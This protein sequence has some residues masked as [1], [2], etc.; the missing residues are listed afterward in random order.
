M[1][2]PEILTVD[3]L[4]EEYSIWLGS[5]GE[6]L[7]LP[8]SL[9]VPIPFC[10]E[11]PVLQ[12]IVSLSRKL[13]S[14]FT[15]QLNG[16]VQDHYDYEK[17]LKN[18]LG[19][20]HI[21]SAWIMSSIVQDQNGIHLNKA[22]SHVFSQ[23]LDAMDS[24]DFPS[25]HGTM[26]DRVNLV[27]VQGAKREFIQPLYHQVNGAP[28]VRPYSDI[29]LLI[30]DI[31]TQLAPDWTGKELRDVSVPLAQL[32]KE[33]VENS[34][35]WARTDESGKTYKKGVRALSFRLVNIDEGNA[36]EFAGKNNHLNNYLQTVLLSHGQSDRG[37]S[38]SKGANNKKNTFVEIS[39]VD[40]GPGLVR[41]WI[42]SLE[43]AQ[44]IVKNL[45]DISIEDEEAFLI[46]CFKKW[47]TSSHNSLR[48]VG[49]FSVAQ[50]LQEKNGF[51]R[52]RTGRLSYLFGTRSAISSVALRMKERI[53]TKGSYYE[54]LPDE[55]HVFTNDGEIVFFLKPWNAGTLSIVEGTSYSIILP[56]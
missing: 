16:L 35:W 3:N 9:P 11:A 14:T 45:S 41:R 46:Q 19:N 29:R 50:L 53:P 44:K 55:T 51:M 48:G 12:Y 8:L 43:S 30:Q 37:K 36:A 20:P 7:N 56:V 26:Q 15:V 5:E 47:A 49:L 33:L 54:R 18:A 17:T 2:L 6:P 10:V 34:D 25:T 1:K 28:V 42:S 32:V 31:L 21:L 40:S 13:D 23:Y 4:E 22:D 27:C 52:L 39:I 24:Y 38:S